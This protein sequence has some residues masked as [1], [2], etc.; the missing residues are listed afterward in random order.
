M[1][2]E[3]LALSYYN[4]SKTSPNPKW[5][6]ISS[7]RWWTSG[8]PFHYWK[9]GQFWTIERLIQSFQG[10]GTCLSLFL[11]LFRLQVYFSWKLPIEKG[12]EPKWKVSFHPL[13]PFAYQ[14]PIWIKVKKASSYLT[15]KIDYKQVTSSF[16]N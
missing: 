14:Q 16:Q 9:L 5:R 15:L 1:K 2:T 10:Y 8:F 11:H 12:N 7:W 13:E 3:E 4:P 6:K